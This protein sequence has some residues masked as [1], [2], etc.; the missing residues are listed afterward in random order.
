VLSEINHDNTTSIPFRLADTRY[1]LTEHKGLLHI[2]N[3]TLLFEV[4]SGI[5]GGYVKE[6]QQFR[7]EPRE[8]H[9]IRL[10]K[11]IFKNQLIF[12]IVAG[13]SLT[14]M[15]GEHR[16]EVKLILSKQ[17]RGT[18]DQILKKVQELKLRT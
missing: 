18:A 3:D 2:E 8:V 15:S 16:E 17:Y 14:T 5:S 13:T 10:K 4:A 12:N 1:G 6:R 7:V 11:G 9:S